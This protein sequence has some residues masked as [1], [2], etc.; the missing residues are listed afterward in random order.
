MVNLKRLIKAEFP[1]FGPRGLIRFKKVVLQT[2]PEACLGNKGGPENVNSLG[3]TRAILLIDS[4][5][6]TPGHCAKF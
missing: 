6:S 5:I 3:A 4:F 2:G 1:H